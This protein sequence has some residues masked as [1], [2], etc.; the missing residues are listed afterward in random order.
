VSL[1]EQ[2]DTRTAAGRLML[3]V[4]ASVAEFEWDSIRERSEAGVMRRL[5]NGGWMGGVCPCGYRVEGKG[6]TA[7]LVI[8]DE[9]FTLPDGTVTTA[10]DIVRLIFRLTVEEH[11]TTVA[12]ADELQRRCVPT[13]YARRGIHMRSH[14]TVVV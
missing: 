6:Q 4:L 11:K 12:I 3:G 5:D 7:R 1:H 2:F 8:D 9:P 14:G 10:A 13:S